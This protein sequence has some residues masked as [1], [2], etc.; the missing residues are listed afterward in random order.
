[1]NVREFTVQGMTC[2]HCVEAVQTQVREVPGIEVASVNLGL[3]LVTVGGHDYTDDA[4]KD[5]IRE[6]GYEV[7]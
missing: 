5:A 7:A 4:V 2:Q 6:A 3:G 1:M